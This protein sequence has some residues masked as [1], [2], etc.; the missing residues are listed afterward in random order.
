MRNM[1][2]IYTDNCTSDELL[3][4]ITLGLDLSEL[5]INGVV[6]S[7][8]MYLIPFPLS[9]KAMRA[10]SRGIYRS[11]KSTPHELLMVLI[12]YLRKL[13]D[14]NYILLSLTKAILDNG[15]KNG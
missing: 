2:K 3:F 15:G 7:Y 5:D 10:N 12:D 8:D 9:D 4:D 14:P 6:E 11:S 13:Y 1:V